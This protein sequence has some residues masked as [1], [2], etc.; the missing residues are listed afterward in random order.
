[1]RRPFVAPATIKAGSLSW[2]RVARGSARDVRALP[3]D[4]EHELVFDDG[5]L[6]LALLVG[7]PFFM[8]SDSSV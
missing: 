7:T 2:R 4:D 3:R 8:N 1:M 6:L 5:P